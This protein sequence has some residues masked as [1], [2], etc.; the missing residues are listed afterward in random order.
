MDYGVT[1][2]PEA[3]DGLTIGAAMGTTE[4]TAGTEVDESTFYATYAWNGFTIGYQSSE[5]DA[6][7]AAASDDST[8]FGISYAVNDDLSISYNEH[9]V[10]VGDSAT[11]QESDGISVS[12]TMGGI[13]IAG[14]KNEMSAVNGASGTDDEGYE[15]MLSF[16]F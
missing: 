11:D 8:A 14:H 1:I 5:A 13:T 16:A 3:V 15:V 6:P 7:T 12:Y 10:D 9:T 2:S 4:I